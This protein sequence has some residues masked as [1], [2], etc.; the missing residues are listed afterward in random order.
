M[1]AFIGVENTVTHVVHNYR[2]CCHLGARMCRHNRKL[3]NSIPADCRPC[4]ICLTERP[5]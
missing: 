4:L 5:E 3:V 1:S 2:F